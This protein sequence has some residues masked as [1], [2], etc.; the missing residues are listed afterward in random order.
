MDTFVWSPQIGAEGETK[1]AQ[2]KAQFG[3]GYAVRVA[4]GLNNISDSWPLS[5]TGESDEVFPIRDFLESHADGRAF[6]WTAPGREQAGL[7]TAAGLKFKSLGGG[8]YT[9]TV[10]LEQTFKPGFRYNGEAQYDGTRQYWS[11]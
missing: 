1:F 8:L 6:F 3:D 11:N 10:T 9:L 2:L 7:Y 4:D 5:F